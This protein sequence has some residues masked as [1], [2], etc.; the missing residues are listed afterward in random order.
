MSSIVD[1]EKYEPLIA[2]TVGVAGTKLFSTPLIN[3]NNTLSSNLDVEFKY[4]DQVE[5][6]YVVVNADTTTSNLQTESGV[7]MTAQISVGTN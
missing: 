7:N 5:Q 3:S 4:F 2:E 6:Q 1:P